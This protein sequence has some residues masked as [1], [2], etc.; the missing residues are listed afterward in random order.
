MRKVSRFACLAPLALAVVL[1]PG[2]ASAQ[3]GKT[4]SSATGKGIVGGGLL[5]AEL[6]L[7]VE[8]AADVE[9]P[10]AYLAGGVLGATGGAIGGYFVEQEG[11]ARASMLLLAGG[12]TL[13]IPTTVAVLAATAY[14]PPADYLQD[15]APADEPVANP[16]QPEGAPP[17]AAPPPVAPVP[18]AS[19]PPAA[20]P[21]AETPPGAAPAP[22]TP[23]SSQAPKARR[24]RLARARKPLPPLH[25]TPPALVD[26]SPTL[27]AVHV[28]AVEVRDTYTRAELAMYGVDQSTEV[29][30]PVLNVAF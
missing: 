10:W 23:P 5:G 6:V 16:P 11:S 26:L 13:A 29:H 27:L 9:S 12:L 25:F 8:A 17:P 3:V 1:A 22:G 21:P 19:T 2:R 20:T 30:I 4:E 14:E 15:S 7:A 18:P 28:P 24:H